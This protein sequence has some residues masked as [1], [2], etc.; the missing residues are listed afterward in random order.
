MSLQPC[1]QRVQPFIVNLPLHS[2]DLLQFI[3]VAGQDNGRRDL[4]TIKSV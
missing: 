3:A 4:H 2:Y 1:L